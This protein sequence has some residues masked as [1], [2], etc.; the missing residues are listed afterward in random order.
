MGLFL[1][2]I[3]IVQLIQWEFCARLENDKMG[4]LW[5]N[6]FSPIHPAKEILGY[7]TVLLISSSHRYR[8]YCENSVTHERCEGSEK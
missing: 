7:L 5:I 3:L 8:L 4:H 6:F 2:P 1:E